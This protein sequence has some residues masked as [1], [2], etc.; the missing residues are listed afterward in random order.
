MRLMKRCIS[1]CFL[2]SMICSS[3]SYAMNFK[4]YWQRG[5]RTSGVMAT[6]DKAKLSDYELRGDGG[7]QMV[8]AE[9][10]DWT[11]GSQTVSGDVGEFYGRLF[12]NGRLSAKPALQY[13]SG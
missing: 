5:V 8:S 7:F 3:S 13:S 1:I 11:S 9:G 2:I 12:I 4:C 10:F 6:M